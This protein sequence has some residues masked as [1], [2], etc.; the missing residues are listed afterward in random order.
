[1]SSVQNSEFAD[2]LYAPIGEEENGMLLTVLSALARIGLDPWQ[3]AGCLTR[4]QTDLATAKM[5]IAYLG[6][7]ERTLGQGGC[8]NHR[9]ASDRAPTCITGFSLAAAGD[10]ARQA[11]AVISG[12]RSR[13]L[14]G[15]RCRDVLRLQGSR[16]FAGPRS[17][18]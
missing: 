14:R 8:R 6:A 4:L 10:Q 13:V 11:S 18:R 16:S 17:S 15:A 1:M 5:G 7:A 2:F 3:E 12:R 9:G